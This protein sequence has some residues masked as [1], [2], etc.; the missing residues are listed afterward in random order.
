MST[1][2]SANSAGPR[3]KAATANAPRCSGTPPPRPGFTTNTKP[4]LPVP[5]TASSYNVET[6]S[7]D[8]NSIFNTY[9]H[10]LAL[11]KA[12]PA[13]RD[14]WQESIND[15]DPN[16][17]AFLRHAGDETV[18]VALNMSAHPHTIAFHLAAEGIAGT[19]SRRSVIPPTHP[20]NPSRSTT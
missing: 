9:K 1:T 15:D 5:P 20:G 4:W 13:L 8:P 2:P 7:K 17:F 6:E 10:L 3:K 12:D 14:G 18:L 11:R 16:V 19:R